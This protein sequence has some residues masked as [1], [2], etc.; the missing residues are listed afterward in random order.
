LSFNK[1]NKFTVKA[2]YWRFAILKRRPSVGGSIKATFFPS[3]LIN[4]T[5]NY[6]AL[7]NAL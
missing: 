2:K 6:K 4:P 7:R 1:S 3:N 5:A